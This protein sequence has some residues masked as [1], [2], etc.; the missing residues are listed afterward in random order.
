MELGAYLKKRGLTQEEF[1]RRLG[2]SQGLVWQWLNG[3]T[4]ITAERAK[5][6]VQS[7]G[8]EVTPYD[9]RPD[10]FPKG[11]MFPPESRKAVN[12]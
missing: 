10:L 5:E 11:F 7:T 1:G 9:L 4:D 12:A 6:I 8:G 2:V 3:E